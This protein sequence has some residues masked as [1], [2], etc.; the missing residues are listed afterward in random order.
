MVT[1]FELESDINKSLKGDSALAQAVQH[2]QARIVRSE[3]KKQVANYKASTSTDDGTPGKMLGMV[4]E[5]IQM[6]KLSIQV[7]LVVVQLV[8]RLQSNFKTL[9]DFYEYDQQ[10]DSTG[11]SPYRGFVSEVS[12]K[13]Q[14][15]VTKEKG[16]ES[17]AIAV[18]NLYISYYNLLGKTLFLLAHLVADDK[19]K[20]Q[21]QQDQLNVKWM[22][23]RAQ[24]MILKLSVLQHQI[25]ADTYTPEAVQALTEIRSQLQ[26]RIASTQSQ[27]DL[28]AKQLSQYES[29]GQG[30]TQ[31]VRQYVNIMENIKDKQWTLDQLSGVAEE[32]GKAHHK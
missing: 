25:A 11:M 28:A 6:P 24:T 10:E 23:T 32:D 1:D 12:R 5:D 3:A 18:D 17:S 9:F 29:L 30:F 2:I 26:S 15:A 14:E 21:V 31:L 13:K 16:L 4:P 8:K 7:N 22:Q 27:H 19:L 20:R